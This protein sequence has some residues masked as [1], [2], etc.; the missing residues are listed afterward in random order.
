MIY[1]NKLVD[2]LIPYVNNAR[3][4]PVEQINKIASSIKE[5]GVINPI[6]IDDKDNV[7]A[8]H[9]RIE[10]AKKLGLKEIP[11]LSVDHLSEAQRKAYILADNRIA[12]DSNTDSL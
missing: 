5:F 9:G 2:D 7:I 1:E 4:H 8:G 12:L 6:I 3:T 11:C 10:A